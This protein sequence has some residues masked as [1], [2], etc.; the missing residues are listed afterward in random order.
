MKKYQVI[1][2]LIVVVLGSIYIFNTTK[3]KVLV[4]NILDTPSKTEVKTNIYDTTPSNISYKEITPSTY[5]VEVPTNWDVSWGDTNGCQITSMNSGQ[6]F[7][8]GYKVQI[9]ITPKSCFDNNSGYDQKSEKDGYIITT[10]NY[11]GF[12]TSDQKKDVAQIYQHVI[13]TIK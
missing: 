8:S 11:D 2:I 7:Q 13:Q 1:L 5:S 10:F 4:V 9:D 6:Y 3:H 12:G